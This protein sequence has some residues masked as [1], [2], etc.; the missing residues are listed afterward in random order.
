MEARNNNIFV[1]LGPFNPYILTDESLDRYNVM[2]NEMENWFEDDG[3]NYRSASDLPSE[4]YADAC[5]PLK[6]GYARI[7]E[8]LFETESF[9]QWINGRK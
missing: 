1:I 4:H 2:K 8:E 5:H 3:I 9:R 7:A 6:E